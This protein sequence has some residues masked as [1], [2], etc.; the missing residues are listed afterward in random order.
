MVQR[1]L[2]LKKVRGFMNQPELVMSIEELKDPK[3]L[4]N[5]LKAKI[6][7]IKGRAYLFLDEINLSR[8]GIRHLNIREFLEAK[9]W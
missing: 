1:E 9:S 2:Y 7:G 5:H 4:H 8:D 6:K 3:K